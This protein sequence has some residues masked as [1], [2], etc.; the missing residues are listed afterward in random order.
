MKPLPM[1]NTQALS[2]LFAITSG[3]QLSKARLKPVADTQ[4]AIAYVSR[5]HQHNGIDGWTA[6]IPGITPSPAG[7]ITVC[8]RSRN[9]ALA[10]FVQPF[11]FYTSYHVAVLTP[12]VPMSTAEKLWWCKCIEQNRFRFNFGRQANRTLGSLLVPSRIPD[13][14]KNLQAPEL[15]VAAS[16]KIDRFSIKD[17]D[18]IKLTDLFELLPG[19]QNVRRNTQTGKTP[20]VSGSIK[21]NGISAYVNLDPEFPAGCL[22][23]A[24]N[25]SIGA[26]FYQPDPFTASADVTVLRPKFDMSL[27]CGLFLCAAIRHESFRYNYARKW[28]LGRM[29]ATKIR[30]PLDEAGN[31]DPRIIEAIVKQSPSATLVEDAF[32]I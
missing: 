20:W 4:G 9:H 19:K 26:T 18:L 27:M 12:L 13:A 17:W 15:T 29:E 8:L 10:S 21:N 25:G 32:I 24:N 6:S 22:T 23:V 7:S 30:F 14:V 3:H 5:T 16:S 11:P 31:A 1:P 2:T 28:T